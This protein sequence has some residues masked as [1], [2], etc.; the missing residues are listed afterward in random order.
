MPLQ[1]KKKNP[2]PTD[3][4]S[5]KGH[6]A[7][8]RGRYLQQKSINYI[9]DNPLKYGIPDYRQEKDPKKRK[10]LKRILNAG[11]GFGGDM[12]G[13]WDIIALPDNRTQIDN[14]NIRQLNFPMLLVQVKSNISFNVSGK[15]TLTQMEYIADLSNFEIPAY[16]RKELH[17]WDY[18]AKMPI[19]L[20]LQ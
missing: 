4:N 11:M 9:L 5:A 15:K 7:R 17:V 14:P 3:E 13:L 12:F 19:I 16:V 18:N 8:S 10:L 1:Y 6:K 20:D 2:N